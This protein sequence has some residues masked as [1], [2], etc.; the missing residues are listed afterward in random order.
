MFCL[1]TENHRVEENLLLTGCN[2]SCLTVF[3]YL[4][5]HLCNFILMANLLLL[6]STKISNIDKS[7]KLGELAKANIMIIAEHQATD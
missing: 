3:H 4:I 6:A 1:H 7:L 5:S 2:L